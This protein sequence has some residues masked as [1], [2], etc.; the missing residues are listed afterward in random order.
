MPPAA[1]RP[2][3]CRGHFT[4]KAGCCPIEVSAANR[5]ITGGQRSA[6]TNL[7]IPTDI[8]QAIDATEV[9]YLNQDDHTN[10]VGFDVQGSDVDKL[11]GAV[12]S[13]I[14]D[15][16]T[17][18]A[19]LARRIP[20]TAGDAD[21]RGILTSS[22]TALKAMIDAGIVL[23]TRSESNGNLL[24][25]W[26]LSV[27]RV[28]KMKGPLDTVAAHGGD[29]M[30]VGAGASQTSGS[31]ATKIRIHRLYDEAEFD[32]AIYMFSTL[33]HM[34]GIMTL[35]IS[36]HFMFE[37]VYVLRSKHK[38]TFW[39]AQ[40][41]LIECL[42]LLDRGMCKAGTVANHDR[43]IMLDNAR[44]LG[45][46]FAEMA[47][48]RGNQDAAPVEGGGPTWNGKFQPSTSKANLCQAFNRNKAHDDPKHLMKDGTCRFRHLC[49]HWVTDKG[50]SGK[51][52]DP[53]HG[54][55]NCNNPNKCKA[56][57]E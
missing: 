28:L 12:Q 20:T 45:L 56:A 43:N 26:V 25:L 9:V 34:L 36:V 13:G 1:P 50:P 17:A 10:D 52:L 38:E 42:D 41:Y 30:V 35:E 3:P 54:W 5:V 57:L 33:A 14:L 8:C 51:C 16:S 46:V 23:K 47:S 49:N 55:H 39:T 24:R 11:M 31:N 6:T 18:M 15:G 2:D 48:K 29:S 27:K 21:A 22:V 32:M 37:A 19:E 53:G 40:E 4:H 7:P 44:R